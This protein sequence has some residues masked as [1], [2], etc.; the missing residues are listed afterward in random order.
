MPILRYSDQNEFDLSHSEQD[1][2]GWTVVDQAGNE[3]GT[4]TELLIDTDAG[5][6]DSI[7]ISGSGAQVSAADIALRDGRVVVRGVVNNE[8]YEQ[9]RNTYA[10]QTAATTNYEAG[11]QKTNSQYV[12]GVTRAATDT[13]QITVPI[14]EEQLRVGKREVEGGGVRVRTVQEEIPVQEQVTLRE[15]HVRVERTPVNRPVSNADASAFREGEVVITESAEVPVVSKEARVVEEVV[16]GKEVTERVETVS[17]T[18]RRTDVDVE[19]VNTNDT[20]R[21]RTSS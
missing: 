1:C 8:E 6:V 9:T 11:R 14:V 16:I 15:E 21:G 5:H 10:T 3:L 18:V 20:T 2:R 7:I 4:V 17:D 12:S 19:E 13:D